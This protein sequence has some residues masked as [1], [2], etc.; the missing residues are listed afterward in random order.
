VQNLANLPQVHAQL[1]DV[2]SAQLGPGGGELRELQKR[3][4]AA[5]GGGECRNLQI[6]HSKVK[7]GRVFEVQLGSRDIPIAVEK[8]LDE[9]LLNS[10]P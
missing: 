10:G 1:C 4:A 8:A 3:A 6:C 7:D 9:P 2:D 5:A